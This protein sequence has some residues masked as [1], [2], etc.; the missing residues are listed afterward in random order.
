MGGWECGDERG[1]GGREGKRDVRGTFFATDRGVGGGCNREGLERFVIKGENAAV[2]CDEVDLVPGGR[3]GRL[4]QEGKPLAGEGCLHHVGLFRDQRFAFA[5]N[6]RGGG[7]GSQRS[8]ESCHLP[9]GE[10]SRD[11]WPS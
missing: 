6:D 11:E 4:C 5:F 10:F 9:T 3:G 7:S 1:E 8:H 2:L